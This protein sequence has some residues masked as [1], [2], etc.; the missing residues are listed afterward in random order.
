MKII[1][2][3][4]IKQF[5]QT[6]VFGIISF[7]MIFVV[8]NMVENIGNFLDQSVPFPI[9]LHYYLVF[10]PEIIKLMTPVAV[11]F[12]ALFTV[13]KAANLS[14]LT[15][16]KAGGVSLYR[17]MVPFLITAFAISLFS[18]YFSGYVVPM[19]NETKEKIE[20]KYLD[21]GYN[22]LGSNIFFQ[23]SKT[24][25][26]SIS[27]FDNSRNQAIKVSIEEFSKDDPTNII[28]RIDAQ[29]M[30]YDTVAHIWTA[31][32]GIQRT[33]TSDNQNASFFTTLQLNY[34]NFKPED[35]SSKQQKPEN[36][37]LSELNKLIDSQKRAGNDPTSTLIE[38]YSRISFPMASIIV[39]FFGLPISANKR[40]GGLAV[41]VGVN[42]LVTF[43][44]LVFMQISLAF[45]KN[46]ALSPLLTAW[47]AN[48]I[49]LAA[50]LINLPRVPQ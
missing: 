11:L 48:L 26:V 4:L 40:R 43:I 29:N 39:V 21:S 18:I 28:S 3:Y 19:A 24:R 7:T 45:G 17:F 1:D 22:Y 50:A 31:H 16:I 6:V 35:L 38:F 34:L 47:S 2:K 46:G 23:D 32:N 15:A 44:Y 5:L 27:Y 41:Q 10:S 30:T 20:V 49:F 9:I 33:L 37:N 25:I 12:A 8:I 13:G 36:M 14:E 42:I